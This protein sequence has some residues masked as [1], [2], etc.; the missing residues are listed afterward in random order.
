MTPSNP[1]NNNPFI[2]RILDS[3]G[4]LHQVA[5]VD[6]THDALVGQT[7]SL[8]VNNVEIEIE[9]ANVPNLLRALADPDSIPTSGSDNL[10]TS[11]GV[12]SALKHLTIERI[13][14]EGT[15]PTSGLSGAVTDSL[16]Y[17]VRNSKDYTPY[18]CIVRCYN[19]LA[20]TTEQW[21][22]GC[23][24]FMQKTSNH[25]AVLITIGTNILSVNGTF[26]GD[27]ET[28]TWDS[29]LYVARLGSWFE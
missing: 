14:D 12:A 23:V 22:I 9:P 8:I 3:L 4:V 29:S 7:V 18:P 17:F 27:L 10:I 16:N 13:D 21:E 1:T 5:P 15:Y 6:H 2:F 20:S 26:T 25:V 24:A 11:G 19:I 28:I